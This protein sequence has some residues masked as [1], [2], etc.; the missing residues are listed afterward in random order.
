MFCSIGNLGMQNFE[1]KA[2]DL[3]TFMYQPTQPSAGL[4]AIPL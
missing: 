4:A 2:D 3:C 1:D